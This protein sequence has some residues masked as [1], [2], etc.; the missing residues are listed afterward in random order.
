MLN[1]FYWWSGGT[2]GN[3]KGGQSSKAIYH[4]GRS[5]TTREKS[6]HQG[7]GHAT[8]RQHMPPAVAMKDVKSSHLTMRL[9]ECHQLNFNTKPALLSSCIIIFQRLLCHCTKLYLLML[10]R[11]SI[12]RKKEDFAP[13]AH[14]HILNLVVLCHLFPWFV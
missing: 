4:P 5:H 10:L 13:G 7:G 12:N 2:Y 14:F 8:R 11:T 6:H 9:E 1:Q 3:Y